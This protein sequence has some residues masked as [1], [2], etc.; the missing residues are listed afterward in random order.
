MFGGL[1]L[2]AYNPIIALCVFAALLALMIYFAPKILRAMKAKLW[3]VFKKLKA[4]ADIGLPATLS[5]TVPANLADVF[6]RHNVLTETIA[7]AAPCISGRGRRIPANLFGALVATNEEPRKLTF[8]ARKRSRGISETIDLEG[9]TVMR[10]P[11]FLAENLVILPIGGKA[12][13]Y[14]FTFPRSSGAAVQEIVDYLKP[15]LAP[16]AEV[17]P[18]AES[19]PALHA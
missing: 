6:S 3:L 4:P 11:K 2:I 13:K 12:P 15:R 17:T 8:V 16:S 7:W 9:C 1:A 14:L 5:L 10:E 19:E 18:I